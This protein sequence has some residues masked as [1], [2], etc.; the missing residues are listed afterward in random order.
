MNNQYPAYPYRQ[1]NEII[2]AFF[3]KPFTLVIAIAY[4]VTALFKFCTESSFTATNTHI[5]FDIFSI[6]LCIAFFLLYFRSRRSNQYVPYKAPIVIIKTVAIIQIV[7]I[8]LALIVLLFCG[9]FFA[10]A[11]QEITYSLGGLMA[12]LLAFYIP[13]LIIALIYAIAMVMFANSVKK[14]V[15]SIFMYK[16]G[17]A[18][19]GVTAFIIAFLSI[20]SLILS[21]IYLPLIMEKLIPFIREYANSSALNIYIREYGSMDG[22]G[23]GLSPLTI[24]DSVI[25]IAVNVLTGIFA[26]SYKFYIDK[27]IST[28]NE[29]GIPG[30]EPSDF[31][32]QFYQAPQNPANNF[33]PQ[34][35]SFDQT[36]NPYAQN[37]QDSQNQQPYNNTPY[38]NPYNSAQICPNCRS[39]CLPNAQF[40]GNCGT[41]LK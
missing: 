16:N 41:R 12:I 2:K 34:N 22:L 27:H 10:V 39:Q 28:I 38:N 11:P 30:N 18:A 29:G 36:Q 13:V 15:S 31:N 4:L 7:I 26:F 3:A 6:L 20:I 35:V 25:S 17:A 37:T 23:V 5:Q 9:V 21:Q 1:N 14:S 32:P 8:G 19:L 24:L 33:E 40:C